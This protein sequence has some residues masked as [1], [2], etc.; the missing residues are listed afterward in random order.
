MRKHPHRSIDIL[1]AL[2]GAES[3]HTHEDD[4]KYG[5]EPSHYRIITDAKLV[6]FFTF[7]KPYHHLGTD[8]V[9]LTHRNGRPG[10]VE[11]F[12]IIESHITMHGLVDI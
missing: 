2:R 4:S 6:I 11:V 12:F 5:D 8:F 1:P 7:S 3:C 10:T 9:P